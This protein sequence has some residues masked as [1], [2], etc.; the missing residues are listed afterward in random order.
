MGMATGEIVDKTGIS[1]TRVNVLRSQ[2]KW[3]K[4]HKQTFPHCS[5]YDFVDADWWGDINRQIA[6]RLYH[7]GCRNKDDV[8]SLLKSGNIV[9]V[10]N[11]GI[12][13]QRLLYQHFLMKDN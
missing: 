5:R 4:E 13:T 8:L 1:K 7:H 9:V 6:N 3:E 10:R 12:K 2:Y 11:I